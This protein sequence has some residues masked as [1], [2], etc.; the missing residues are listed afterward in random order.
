M[1]FIILPIVLVVA[2]L[3]EAGAFDDGEET[4]EVS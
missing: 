4:T 3:L 2:F 1:N